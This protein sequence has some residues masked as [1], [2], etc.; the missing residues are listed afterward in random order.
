MTTNF[1]QRREQNRFAHSATVRRRE[2][3][4]GASAPSQPAHQLWL[5]GSL[6]E[7]HF[8][9]SLNLRWA[10]GWGD[11]KSK[12]CI[13]EVAVRRKSAYQR[14]RHNF[15]LKD[16]E[17]VWDVAADVWEHRGTRVWKQ[18]VSRT[19]NVKRKYMEKHGHASQPPVGTGA[20]LASPQRCEG[21]YLPLASAAWKTR[22]GC[23][24]SHGLRG[25]LQHFQL[26]TGDFN[27]SE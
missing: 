9:S 4:L 2:A 12:R 3:L 5:N 20:G 11:L 18:W 25:S 8:K 13:P 21:G 7:R 23:Q 10:S 26:S 6:G 15:F 27:N 14:S 17:A 19:E 1:F 22:G 16:A 24:G